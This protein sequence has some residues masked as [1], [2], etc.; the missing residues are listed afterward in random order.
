MT[1]SF[2]SVLNLKESRPSA[3][4]E[5]RR[6]FGPLALASSTT[7]NATPADIAVEYPEGCKDIYKER[8]GIGDYFTVFAEPETPTGVE[9]TL[10][11]RSSAGA[12]RKV[13]RNGR[14]TIIRGTRTYSLFG[15]GL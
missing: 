7:G 1:K 2:P 5:T 8:A 9:E 4:P 10:G 12:A 13:M 14:V 11:A 6:I 3:T 15:Q